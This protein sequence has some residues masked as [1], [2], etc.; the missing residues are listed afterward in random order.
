VVDPI[1]ICPTCRKPV[2]I[3]GD[4]LMCASVKAVLV[5]FHQA[6]PSR[7]LSEGVKPGKRRK[8]RTELVVTD[9]HLARPRLSEFTKPASKGQKPWVT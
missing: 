2:F 7:E 5:K 3:L 4:C 8:P 9:K 6:R 1:G